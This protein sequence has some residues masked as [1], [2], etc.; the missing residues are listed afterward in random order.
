LRRLP[1]IEGLR[2]RLPSFRDVIQ[3]D[4]LSHVAWEMCLAWHS[5]DNRNRSCPQSRS[6]PAIMTWRGSIPAS[7][8]KDARKSRS[9]RA[10]EIHCQHGCPNDYAGE[11]H[12][13]RR[14]AA[15]VPGRNILR[16]EGSSASPFSQNNGGGRR[17]EDQSSRLRGQRQTRRPAEPERNASW[18]C[19]TTERRRATMPPGSTPPPCRVGD[20][21]KTPE[22]W[23][24]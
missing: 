6:H 3:Q 1:W 16:D 19:P 22:P 4:G 14:C 9:A 18:A 7:S 20:A 12:R 24:G 5:R 8:W 2:L 11:K 13:N 17:E 10:V 23:A 21:S 15:P